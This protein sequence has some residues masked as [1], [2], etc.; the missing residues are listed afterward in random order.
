M[1][2]GGNMDIFYVKM[3]ERY[4][5]GILV[6]MHMYKLMDLLFLLQDVVCVCVCVCVCVIYY[7]YYLILMPNLFMFLFVENVPLLY[8]I[9][10]YH[11][12][13]L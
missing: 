6:K 13:L 4:I 10:L 11:T 7:F 3:H 9:V 2:L 8:K 1:G 5:Y 12:L